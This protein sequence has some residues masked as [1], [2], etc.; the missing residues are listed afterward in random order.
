[1]PRLV[2]ASASPRR[3]ELL[4]SLG[5]EFE[6]RPVDLDETPRPGEAPEAYVARLAREKAAA[7]LQLGGRGPGELVLAADTVVVLDGELLGKPADPAEARAMLRRLAGREHTVHTGVEL[8][9]DTGS[10]VRR[11]A[12][13]ATSRVR[14]A[15]LDD[16]TIAWYV[17]T[18]EPLD[19]A[20]AYAIQDLGALFVEAVDGNYTNV[21]GLPV[22]TVW[23]LF[24][25]LGED[26]LAFRAR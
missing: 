22:P 26:L 17:A 1:M 23:R 18:G 5:L 9:E 13:V 21:V 3:R 2:L 19:K 12:A 24:R 7:A 16:P 8:A 15:A 20:G 11:A 14:I 10:G 6:V 4:A 25:E